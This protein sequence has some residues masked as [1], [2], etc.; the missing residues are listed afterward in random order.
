M[1][2]NGIMSKHGETK[3]PVHIWNN[4][5]DWLDWNE[6]WY[7]GHG[8]LMFRDLLLRYRFPNKDSKLQ[9][10]NQNKYALGY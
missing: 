7:S 3:L 8:Y 9:A 1:W 6:F 10:V 2:W 4:W 5:L